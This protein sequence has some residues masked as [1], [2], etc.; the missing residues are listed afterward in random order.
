M[1]YVKTGRK[2]KI[3][4]F[5]LKKKLNLETCQ[6]RMNAIV[7]FRKQLNVRSERLKIQG[8]RSFTEVNVFCNRLV[9][10]ETPNGVSS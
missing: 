5:H 10:N 2:F 6:V 7:H 8:I 4:L 3:K 9:T 1:L